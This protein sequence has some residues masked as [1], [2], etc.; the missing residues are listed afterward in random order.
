M[1]TLVPPSPRAALPPARLRQNSNPTI[2][3]RILSVLVALKVY[4]Y[5][6]SGADKRVM[7]GR[8]RCFVA[9]LGDSGSAHHFSRTNV[10]SPSTIREFE[11]GDRRDG[12]AA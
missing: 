10:T 4:L 12:N 5:W 7:F 8:Q 9:R 11:M 1:Y 3:T 6:L 2:T